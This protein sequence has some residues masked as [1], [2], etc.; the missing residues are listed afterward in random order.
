MKRTKKF[1][2]RL[3]EREYATREAKAKA[4]AKAKA[5]G[6]TVSEFVRQRCRSAGRPAGKARRPAAVPVV[7]AE[8]EPEVCVHGVSGLASARAQPLTDIDASNH[9]TELARQTVGA[10]GERII[11]MATAC[12]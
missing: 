1:E 8:V 11:E 12:V 7:D 4:K 5:L 3:A 9:M 2:L 6:V 10:L